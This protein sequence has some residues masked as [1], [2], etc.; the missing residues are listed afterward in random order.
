VELKECMRKNIST[1]LIEELL[2]SID[3][4][5]IEKTI[6]TLQIARQSKDTSEVLKEFIIISTCKEFGINKKELLV[7]KKYTAQRK[8]AIGVASILLKQHCNIS[9]S[10]IAIILRKDN[11]NI[12]KYIKK[13]NRLD[14]NFKEDRIVLV[15][16][17][18][19]QHLI[20]EFS[21][22]ILNNG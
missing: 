5:G 18:N 3:E 17:E 22:K 14:A 12:S 13:Y 8:N 9:Q 11:S 21:T 15:H 19:L 2:R 10:K 1:Q 6:G 4:I 16:I 20:K 7:G